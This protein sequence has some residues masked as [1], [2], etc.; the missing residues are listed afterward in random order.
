[1]RVLAVSHQRDAGPGVFADAVREGGHELITWHIAEKGEPPGDP[2]SYDAVMTFGGAMHADQEAEHR[3]LASEK[4][5]LRGLLEDGMPLLGVCLGSQLLAEAA[6]GRAVRA[7]EP[8][9]GWFE[10]EVADA[11]SADPV[12]GALAPSFEAFEWHSYAV[13]LPEEATVLARTPLCVQAYRVRDAA[14]GIQFHAEV[15]AADVR[16][17][18]DAYR[19]DEDAVRIGMDPRR[20]RAA[21]DER[22]ESFNELG[23]ELCSRW[24]AAAR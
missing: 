11:G 21:T 1:V 18:I 23:R 15:S 16:K 9:I 22:I 2:G 3:W 13:E 20:L 17:W 8:E 10:I 6:G 5:L 24:L 19:T 4:S 14:W 12:L 7:S